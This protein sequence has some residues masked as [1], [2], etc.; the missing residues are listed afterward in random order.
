MSNKEP[1]PAETL[2]QRFR[3]ELKKPFAERYFSEDELVNVCDSASDNLEDYLRFEALL[4][5]AR[6]YPDST[7]LL[8]R[9][10]V[11]YLDTDRTLFEKLM[12]DNTDVDSPI[13]NVLRLALLD[14]KADDEVRAQ[15]DKYIE[16]FKFTED[17]EVI[18]FV[19][20]VHDLGQDEWLVENFDKLK[21]KVPYL[22]SLLYEF[23]LC[24]DENQIMFDTALRAL[25]ELTEIDP[26]VSDYWT[27]LTMAHLRKDDNEGA[28]KAL[29]YSLAID[30]EDYPALALRMQIAG[31]MNDKTLL[32]ETVKRMLAINPDDNE[33][34]GFALMIFGSNDSVEGNAFIDSLSDQAKANRLVLMY[35]I[36]SD[37]EHLDKLLENYYDRGSQDVEEWSGLA[38]FA[39]NLAKLD[40]IVSIFRIYEAKSGTKIPNDFL[41]LS[42]A[43]N[44][45]NYEVAVEIFENALPDGTL[46]SP[47][48]L[49]SAFSIYLLSLLRLGRDS[50]ALS[51]ALNLLNFMRDPANDP[52]GNRLEQKAVI[53]FLEDVIKR[54]GQKRKTNWNNIDPLVK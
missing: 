22:P 17:E 23:A 8:E 37:Y 4:L 21:K 2:R 33:V 16:G 46:R 29:E 10:A 36:G 47:E 18:Q 3:E 39:F 52:L 32:K 20:I 40:S 42:L 11:L 25:E 31:A 1:S 30:P 54:I 51:E 27:M 53:D 28:L 34:P 48:N 7:P 5:G 38:D 44:H 14:S 41:I 15:L 45:E 49:Y 12:E 19:Q 24:A 6:L 9:K 50:Q 13:M 43:F 35:A 26:Y